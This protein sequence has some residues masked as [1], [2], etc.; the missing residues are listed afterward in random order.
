MTQ[1]ERLKHLADQVAAAKEAKIKAE[2]RMAE[3]ARREEEILAKLRAKGF[4]PDAL[5]QER[6]QRE[7]KLEQLLSQ[8][9]ATL[10][11]SKAAPAADRTPE[12]PSPAQ[13][14]EDDIPW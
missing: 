6:Q 9:E 4:D 7:E 11:G 2:A 14:G 13:A 10:R 3:L 1:E 5:D 12:P 8:I